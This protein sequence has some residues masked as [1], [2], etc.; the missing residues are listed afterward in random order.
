MRPE[1]VETDAI[2][3]EAGMAPGFLLQERAH[4]QRK[5]S[6]PFLHSTAPR[7]SKNTV[8]TFWRPYSLTST[9]ISRPAE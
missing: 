2:L 8:P 9:T 1:P 3:S 5:W 7:T 6:L 4:V